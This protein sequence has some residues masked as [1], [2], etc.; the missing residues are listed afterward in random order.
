MR[1]LLIILLVCVLPT[2]AA[3]RMVSY[4]RA[5]EE[6]SKEVGKLPKS[7]VYIYNVCGGSYGVKGPGA[8]RFETGLTL[9]S[10]IL[11]AGG[12][13]KNKD[14]TY[15]EVLRPSKEISNPSEGKYVYRCT[16]PQNED[17]EKKF[18]NFILKVGDL[19]LIHAGIEALA[20]LAPNQSLHATFAAARQTRVSSIR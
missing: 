14:L 17:E 5:V 9:R 7:P 16:V 18:G 8:Y 19:V 3:R 11:K 20:R 6:L 15:I 13:N 4:S 2:L 10:L 1:Y 12:F